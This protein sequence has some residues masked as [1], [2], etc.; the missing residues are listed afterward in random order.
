MLGLSF[1]KFD[2][3]SYMVAVAKITYKKIG[4]LI[5]SMNFIS[6]EV[7]RYFYKSTIWSCMEY[8]C[9]VCAGALNCYFDMLDELQKWVC[10]IAGPSLAV[11]LEPLVICRKLA[12]LSLFYR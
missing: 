6:L 3:D 8:Y 12:S 10:G 4:A 11:S 2:W 5:R 7:S 9:D 1:N